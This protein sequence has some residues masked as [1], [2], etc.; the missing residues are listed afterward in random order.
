MVPIV[1]G[2]APANACQFQIR[3]VPSHE[4]EYKKLCLCL[5][6]PAGVMNPSWLTELVW[7]FSRISEISKPL[8]NP[9]T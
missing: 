8:S 3:T 4:V 7:P 2:R 9:R 6:F 1:G 5:D